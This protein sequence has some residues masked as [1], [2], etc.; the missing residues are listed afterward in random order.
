MC[1]LSRRENDVAGTC[2]GHVRAKSAG[3]EVALSH[4]GSRECKWDTLAF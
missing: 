4:E 1:G 2:E 3:D